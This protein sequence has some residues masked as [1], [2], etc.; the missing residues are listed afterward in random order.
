MAKGEKMDVNETNK[1]S[2]KGKVIESIDFSDEYR[3]NYESI[4]T[5]FSDGSILNVLPAYDHNRG[6][7][8]VYFVL[9]N[10]NTQ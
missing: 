4:K 8:Y 1:D 6:D 3:G 7:S 2:L 9:D 10:E 5:V